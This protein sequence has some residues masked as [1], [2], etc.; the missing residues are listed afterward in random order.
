MFFG[1]TEKSPNLPVG[2]RQKI[3]VFCFLRHS[4]TFFYKT[5]FCECDHAC[6]EAVGYDL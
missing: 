2:R 6:L 5:K 1:H 4:L 3:P